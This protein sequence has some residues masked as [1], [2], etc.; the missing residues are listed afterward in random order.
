MPFWGDWS[1]PFY[2]RMNRAVAMET[3]SESHSDALHNLLPAQDPA[4]TP[5]KGSRLTR[6]RRRAVGQ[7]WRRPWYARRCGAIMEP[8][9]R[10]VTNVTNS[11]DQLLALLLKQD[12]GS[13][14]S[15]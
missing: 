6:G 5:S 14:L 10:S 7:A 1:C 12:L 4:K 11:V 3:S 8:N 9:E 2:T 13:S 15:Y